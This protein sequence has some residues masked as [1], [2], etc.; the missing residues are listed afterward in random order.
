MWLDMA[1]SALVARYMS[2]FFFFKE[3]LSREEDSNY[4]LLV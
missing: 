2:L 1:A 4:S 3:E